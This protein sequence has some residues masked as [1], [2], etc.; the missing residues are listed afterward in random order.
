[1]YNSSAQGKVPYL[2]VQITNQFAKNIKG[3][4]FALVILETDKIKDRPLRGEQH[5]ELPPRHYNHKT[6]SQI[7]MSYTINKP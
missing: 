7:F 4:R 1:M 3:R 2:T 6:P 5:F